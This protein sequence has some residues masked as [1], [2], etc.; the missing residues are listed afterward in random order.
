MEGRTVY[1][2]EIRDLRI[3]QKVYRNY[4]RVL[5]GKLTGSPAERKIQFAMR[6]TERPEGLLLSGADEDGNEAAESGLDM[7]GRLVMTT[8]YCLRR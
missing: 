5:A 2:R 7:S 6:L 4:D 3:G 1:P 8:K